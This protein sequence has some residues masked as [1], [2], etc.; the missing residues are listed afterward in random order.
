[1]VQ[2]GGKMWKNVVEKCSVEMFGE[3]MSCLKRIRGYNTGEER[4]GNRHSFAR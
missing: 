4:G 2:F 3:K 1:M